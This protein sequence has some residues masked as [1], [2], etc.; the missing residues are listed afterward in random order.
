[1]SSRQASTSDALIERIRSVL[2]PAGAR[3]LLR[4][5]DDVVVATS[6]GE[7]PENQ[8]RAIAARASG[9]AQPRLIAVVCDGMGGMAEGARCAATAASV[10]VGR[11]LAAHALNPL[12]I[13]SAI[14]DANAV[15]HRS[16][17][18]GGGA[19]LVAY[20][21]DGTGRSYV[22]H[23][24]DSRAYLVD[25]TRKLRLL[26]RD[27]TIAALA[28]DASDATGATLDSRLVQ[29]VGCGSEIRPHVSAVPEGAQAVLLTTDGAHGPANGLLQDLVRH[30]PSLADL[31][32]RLTSL[33]LWT[34]GRDNATVLAINIRALARSSPP[35]HVVELVTTSR[36]IEIWAE[37]AMESDRR[38]APRKSGKLP[39]VGPVAPKAPP[40]A[41]GRSK[42]RDKRP[43]TRLVVE[44]G[45]TGPS[46]GDTE[47]RSSTQRELSLES[48]DT[49]DNDSDR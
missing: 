41:P 37:L 23:V 7:R 17:V 14:E 22:G 24:G 28:G 29:F 44:V 8:D 25:S 40:E 20:V 1:V 5:D 13:T 34:G 21:Q 18:G 3:E 35:A 6:I 46:A 49:D 2:A 42:R 15:I 45:S 9:V 31:A 38:T 30:A 12:T 16:Y 43:A 33:S 10:F 32:E 11:L 26:T 39:P 27:D 19:T 4:L 47:S 36:R 48:N